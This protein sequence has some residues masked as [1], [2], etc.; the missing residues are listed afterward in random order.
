M[1]LFVPVVCIKASSFCIARVSLVGV[2]WL[3]RPLYV[4]TVIRLR[5]L[6]SVYTRLLPLISME[7]L[8]DFFVDF[9]DDPYNWRDDDTDS[10]DDSECEEET[11]GADAK[12]PED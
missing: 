10:A 3:N 6:T 7:S 4:F 12:M 2:L 9:S 8:E 5:K 11:S 1:S